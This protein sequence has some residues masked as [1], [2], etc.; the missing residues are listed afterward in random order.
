MQAA[1]ESGNYWRK[2]P[3][4]AA[5]ESH[6]SSIVNSVVDDF[7]FRDR[8]ESFDRMTNTSSTAFMET[9]ETWRL[10]LPPV[11]FPLRDALVSFQE[12]TDRPPSYRT[13]AAMARS[14][15]ESAAGSFKVTQTAKSRAL[16]KVGK[17][18][19]KGQY[20]PSWG[21]AE[22]PA[23]STPRAPAE[24]DRP[25]TAPKSL[26][27]AATKGK[28]SR[29]RAAE[30]A[31]GEMFQ[32]IEE[33]QSTP[34]LH[35]ST[36]SDGFQ[37]AKSMSRTMSCTFDDIRPTWTSA[38]RAVLGHSRRVASTRKAQKGNASAEDLAADDALPQGSLVV[39]ASWAGMSMSSNRLAP[40]PVKEW[41]GKGLEFTDGGLGIGDRFD[42]DI[43][44]AARRSPGCVY[45][46]QSFG[47]V[48]RWNAQTS[49]S[50]PT[51]QPESRHT[52]AEAHRMGVRREI[53]RKSQRQPGPGYYELKGMVEEL[54]HKNSKRPKPPNK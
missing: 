47:S 37:G 48:S 1:A 26:P 27:S 7:R 42:L 28:H 54:Y 35:A 4:D 8:G 45:E 52:S 50:M 53:V 25:K 34:D 15:S 12:S 10:P 20:A 39:D 13:A 6:A 21:Y 2:L 32:P 31:G 23:M 24:C 33:S 38:A 44:V 51:K 5:A 17:M 43:K 22:E 3:I 40:R 14:A 49:P 9:G 11:R 46:Q 19:R 30:A 16:R 36:A 29:L 18:R 41:A